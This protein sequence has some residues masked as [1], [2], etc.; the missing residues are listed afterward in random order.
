MLKEKIK[1]LPNSPGCYLMKNQQGI[2]IYVGKA[3]NL[4]SRVSSYFNVKHIGKTKSLVSNIYDF[5]YIITNNEKEAL[6]LELNLIKKYKPKYNV[7]LKDDKTYPYIELTNELY[8]QLNIVRNHF[9]RKKKTKLFGPYPNVQAA[10]KTVNLLNRIYPLRKCK[11]LG[12]KPCLYYHIGECLGYCVNAII[13]EEIT[14]MV[15]EITSFLNGNNQFLINRLKK[16]MKTAANHLDFEKAQELKSL[17]DDIEVTINKQYININDQVDRDIFNYYQEDEYIAIQL[18]HLRGGKLVARD[19]TIYPLIEDVKEELTYYIYSFYDR[20]NLKPNEILIPNIIDINFLETLLGIKVTNPKRGQ[21]RE[22]LNLAHKNAELAI[23]NKGKIIKAENE[24]EEL[25]NKQLGQLLGISYLS[26]IEI[27][28][29]SHLFGTFSVSGMVVFEDGKPKRSEYRK[30]QITS[31]QHDDYHLME[32]VIYRRYT[33][34]LKENLPLADLIIVD[35]GIIQINAALNVLAKLQLK[36][37][38]CGLKKNENHRTQALIYQGKVISIATNSPLFHFLERMSSE[39]HRFTISYHQKIRSK[40]AL[41]SILDEVPGIGSSR[42]V[43]LLKKY[44]SLDKIKTAPTSELDA[45]LTTKVTK[46]LKERLE[47]L[48]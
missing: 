5:D 9:N 16:E 37:P 20:G 46:L 19:S 43:K 24:K 21:K 28:D 17:L 10:R 23:K 8:P 27:F 11:H 25:L 48:K 40:G 38:V 42:R 4:K 13:P 14:N 7:L 22:L 45:I 15:K 30:Y 3:N 47:Q 35:G 26:R 18:L 41:T 36:I 39:V 12:K 33:R 34:V 2:I 32:E 29:N 31:K 6:I 1:L 44:G